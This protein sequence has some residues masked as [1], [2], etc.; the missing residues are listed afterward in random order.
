MTELLSPTVTTPP[1]VH[2]WDLDDVPELEFDPFLARQLREEPV[3]R[4]R[5][6]YSTGHAWLVTRYEDVRLVTSDPRFSRTAVAGKDVTRMTPHQIAANEAVGYADPPE[7]TRLRRTVAKAFTSRRMDSLRLRA[8][9]IADELADTMADH[10]P[11]LDLVA[12]LHMHKPLLPV[13]W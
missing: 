8:R 2:P 13:V 9:R 5:L 3:S 10:G 12:H 7:H 4:I 11:P 1:P 6:P